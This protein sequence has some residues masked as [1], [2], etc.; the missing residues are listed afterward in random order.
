[1]DN[2]DTTVPVTRESFNPE[3]DIA[4]FMGPITSRYRR[5]SA[6]ELKTLMK[7]GGRFAIVD[8][9]KPADYKLGHICGSAVVPVD[10]IEEKFQSVD[11][12]RFIIVYG[13]ASWSAEGVV[14]ADKLN[15]LSFHNVLVLEGGIWAWKKAGGCLELEANPTASLN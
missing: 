7:T 6:E 13:G 1:M 3:N 15:T 10:S 11:P 5:I 2:Y 12:E 9:R 14:A 8:V 4:L